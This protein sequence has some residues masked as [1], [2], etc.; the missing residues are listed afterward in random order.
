[1]FIT[2]CDLCKKEISDKSVTVHIGFS[3]RFEFC[4]ECGLPIF[5]FLEN[6]NLLEKV[7]PL[8]NLED[9]EKLSKICKNFA[10]KHKITQKQV[11]END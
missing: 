9:F 11:L 2:K 4:Q 1:M 8:K 5:N 3:P 10:K 7:R 6:S